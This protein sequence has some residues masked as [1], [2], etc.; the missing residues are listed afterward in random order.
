MLVAD[1]PTTAL[2][3]TIQAQI[4][5]LLKRLQKAI[6]MALL[7]ITHDLSLVAGI[8]DRVAVMYAAFIVEQGPV[9]DIFRDPRHPYTRGLLGALPQWGGGNAERLSAIPGSPPGLRQAFSS[10]PFAPRC[11][12]VVD[13]CRAENPPLVPS[14]PRRSA[15]CWRLEQP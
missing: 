13:R 11:P 6:G 14:G 4:V 15:A 12:E 3:V 2:D 9:R 8:A 10:C 5:D 7:W 1:E